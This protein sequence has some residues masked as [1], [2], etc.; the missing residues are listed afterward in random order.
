[1]W[2]ARALEL[3]GRH[4]RRAVANGEDLEAP[5]AA[6]P[7][8]HHRAATLLAGAP[9]ADPDE[10]TLPRLLTALM[11]DVGAPGGVRALGY[12]D[13]DVEDLVSGALKQQRLLDIAPIEVGAEQLEAI[14]RD[15][16]A[17]CETG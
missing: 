13:E 5:G 15:S 2:S 14:V 1:M 3:G 11:R 12:G 8:K 17:H 6:D 9:I 10:E 4:L 16:M 7:T